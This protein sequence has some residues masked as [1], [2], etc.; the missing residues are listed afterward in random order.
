MMT[1]ELPRTE[2]GEVE[3]P[4]KIAHHV[5]TV[6]IK[7]SPSFRIKYGTDVDV[8]VDEDALVDAI[9]DAITAIDANA[10]AEERERCACVAASYDIQNHVLDYVC[11]GIATEIR[12]MEDK[13]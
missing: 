5:K 2:S 1:Y 13:T 11:Q 8:L 6:A 9:A 3:T 4:T 10:R 7:L 12:A